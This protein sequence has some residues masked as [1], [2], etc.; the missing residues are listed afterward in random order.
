MKG[1]TGW[2]CGPNL[3]HTVIIIAGVVIALR[4]TGNLPSRSTVINSGIMLGREIYLAKREPR[5]F[6]LIIKEADP[7]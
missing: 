2:Q 3:A 1:I 7:H 6:V 4:T 5:I